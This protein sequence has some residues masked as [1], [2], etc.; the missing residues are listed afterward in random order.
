ML[1]FAQLLPT[2][3]LPDTTIVWNGNPIAGS[4]EFAAMLQSMPVSKHDLQ[5]FDCHPIG[6]RQ[7]AREYLPRKNEQALQELSSS[8]R[9]MM[10]R[11]SALQLASPT[12]LG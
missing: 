8:K 6:G 10:P 3:Y 9:A 11:A 1:A 4:R 5:S 2:L 12:L 7:Q